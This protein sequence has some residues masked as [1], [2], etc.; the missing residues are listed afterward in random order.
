[1]NPKEYE[2]LQARLTD[3][4][5]KKERQSIRAPYP[6][7]DWKDAIL[8]VKSMIHSEFKVEP[9][10]DWRPVT[11]RG[12]ESSGTQ[13]L[14]KDI[15]EECMVGWIFEDLDSDTGFSAQNEGVYMYDVVK[16]MRIPE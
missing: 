7:G 2:R 8:A 15:H 12:W 14:C 16:W 10:E 3:L 5:N 6:I 1:M 4:L 9:R 11:D 13:L